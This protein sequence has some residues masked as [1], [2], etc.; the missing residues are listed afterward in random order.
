MKTLTLKIVKS[1]FVSA[2]IGLMIL[3]ASIPLGYGAWIVVLAYLVFFPILYFAWRGKLKPKW[4]WAWSVR[5]FLFIYSLGVLF[6]WIYGEI[7]E[8]GLNFKCIYLDLSGKEFTFQM[9]VDEHGR[10]K[11]ICYENPP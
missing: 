1:L 11:N 9:S 4:V 10:G 2:G 3:F 6:L 5:R 7:L 8:Y